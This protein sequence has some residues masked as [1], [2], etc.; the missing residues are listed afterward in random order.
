MN[1]HVIKHFIYIVGIGFLLFWL[2]GHFYYPLHHSD[3]TDQ[4][5]ATLSHALH[6]LTEIQ[7][8]DIINI[9]KSNHLGGGRSLVI[10]ARGNFKDDLIINR[11]IENDWEDIEIGTTVVTAKKKNYYI[12]IQQKRSRYTLALT[13]KR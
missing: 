1:N 4:D 3:Y 11:M 13:V 7:Q 8:S 5:E 6:D 12:K 10:E 9:Q 2:W